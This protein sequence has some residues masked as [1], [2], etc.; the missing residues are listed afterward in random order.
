MSYTTPG[1]GPETAAL[2]EGREYVFLLEKE[3]GGD[4]YFLV[5]STQGAYGIEAGRPVAGPDN[6]VSLSPD[7]LKA[8]RLTGTG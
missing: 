3:E 5:N 8:L 2:T 6:D 7:V 1:S 4:G